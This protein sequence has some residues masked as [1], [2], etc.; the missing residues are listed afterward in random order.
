MNLNECRSQ[1][2]EIDNKMKELFLKRMEIVAKVATYKKNN[3]LAIFDARREEEMKKRL[4][5][6]I[7]DE[8]KKEYLQFLESILVISKDYQKKKIL[9]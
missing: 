2:N 6:N 3:N 8:L 7:N 4:L 9:F 5:E 1:I